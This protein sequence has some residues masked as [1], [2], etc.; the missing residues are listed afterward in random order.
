MA[1]LLQLAQSVAGATYFTFWPGWT[2]VTGG[3]VLPRT[4]APGDTVGALGSLVAAD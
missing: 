1:D 4:L 3:F 2:L